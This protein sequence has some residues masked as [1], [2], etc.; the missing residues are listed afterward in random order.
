M[1]TAADTVLPASLARLPYWL[2]V[3]TASNA[4]L[5][6]TL[7]NPTPCSARAMLPLF[8]RGALFTAAGVAAELSF[9]DLEPI[10]PDIFTKAADCPSAKIVV[11]STG[12]VAIR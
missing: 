8:T 5:R 2:L 12:N 1:D 3:D 11:I 6:A 4:P 10:E 7:E 9:F